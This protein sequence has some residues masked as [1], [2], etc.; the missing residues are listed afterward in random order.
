[1]SETFNA[2]VPISVTLYAT[3]PHFQ[4][5]LNANLGIY[6]QDAWT[7]KRLTLNVGLR[8]DYLNEQVTG[9]PAQPGTFAYIPAFGDIQPATQKNFSPRLSV[10]YDLS[11]NGKTA[12]RFGYNK[13][14]D[15]A[16]TGLASAIDPANGANITQAVSWTDLNHDG[17]AQYY[18]THDAN[19][20]LVGCVYL[21]PGCEINFAQVKAGFGTV[22]P[23]QYDPNFKRP[24]IDAY[25]L[26]ISHE[27]FPGVSVTG[28]W[29]RTVGRNLSFGS[30]ASPDY[31][32]RQ[33]MI[34]PDGS[35]TNPSYRAVTVFSPFDG[36][37]VTVY[38]TTAQSQPLQQALIITD[39]N[40]T[41][42][43]NG[44]DLNFSAR[45][46]GGAR[47]FG[48]TTTERTLSNTCSTAVNN[49]N[50]LNYCDQ[51]KSGIPWRTQFKLSAS[52]PLPWYGIQ[53]S[54]VYQALPGYVLSS[55]TG[56]TY[57]VTGMTRYTV[58]PGNSPAQGCVV[59]ALIDP[60]QVVSS[61]S[62][63]LDPPGTTLTPRIN[64]VD[65]GLAKRITVGRAKINPKGDLFN[66]LNSSDYFTVRTQTYSPSTTPGQVPLTPS[67]QF[68]P[69]TSGSAFRQPGSILQGRILRL[70]ATVNW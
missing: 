37:G 20:N 14:M 4:E 27:L 25:N 62:V 66:V 24:S 60:G 19:N 55:A 17:V 45:L 5:R 3:S 56:A 18:V 52:Y 58:C 67:A 50:N 47:I 61:L 57:T 30:S 12:V 48:G 8:W 64:Q 7:L 54:G 10:V 68:L 6:G 53:V 1:M 35:V 33:G 42:V 49:P 36:H 70:G 65:I 32:Q 43:Y 63:P 34:N 22:Q 11:G 16:T 2:G 28:E 59:G 69:S 9:Q 26:G 39:P 41:S 23:T 13:F 44:F 51:S 29:F 40:R 31:I 46:P 15:A 38:D 21:T